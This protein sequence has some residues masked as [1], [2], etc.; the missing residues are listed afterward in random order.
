MGVKYWVST[1]T[2]ELAFHRRGKC[3]CMG[4]EVTHDKHWLSL[5]VKQFKHST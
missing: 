3:S 4:I 1:H 5:G 2:G